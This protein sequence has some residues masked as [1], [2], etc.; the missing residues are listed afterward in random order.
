MI[1]QPF[2]ARSVKFAIDASF[3]LWRQYGSEGAISPPIILVEHEGTEIA[4]ASAASNEV[5]GAGHLI[6]PEWWKVGGVGAAVKGCA[7][8]FETIGEVDG[9][10]HFHRFGTKPMGDQGPRAE[11]WRYFDE[12]VGE[13]SAFDPVRFRRSGSEQYPWR[14]HPR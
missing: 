7:E 9:Y 2:A 3:P 5:F 4:I 10:I 14:A 11:A 13:F 1:L 8:V 12:F 6:H